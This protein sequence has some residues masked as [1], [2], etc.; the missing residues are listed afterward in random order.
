MHGC[1]RSTW[2]KRVGKE[3]NFPGILEPTGPLLLNYL[4][5]SVPNASRTEMT[6]EPEPNCLSRRLILNRNR[7]KADDERSRSYEYLCRKLGMR[8]WCLPFVDFIVGCFLS[9]FESYRVR[10]SGLLRFIFKNKSFHY[11]SV[12]WYN[13]PARVRWILNY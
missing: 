3:P 9:E 7:D 6:L 11:C 2:S 1:A 10:K 13:F 4:S 12:L 8:T 5:K